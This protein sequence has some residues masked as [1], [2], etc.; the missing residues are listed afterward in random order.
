MKRH[1]RE[2]SRDWD[3]GVYW[4]FKRKTAVSS[5]YVTL[6]RLVLLPEA[7]TWDKYGGSLAGGKRKT[8]WLPSVGLWRRVVW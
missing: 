3:F 8:E 5:F 2:Q 4:Y 7:V 6:F 1:I